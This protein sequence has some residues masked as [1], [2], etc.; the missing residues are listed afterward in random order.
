MTKGYVL[1]DVAVKA[2]YRFFTAVAFLY[3]LILLLTHVHP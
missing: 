2:V 1:S 3:V